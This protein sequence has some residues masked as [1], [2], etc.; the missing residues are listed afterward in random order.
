MSSARGWGPEIENSQ[1]QD[2]K[3]LTLQGSNAVQV[4]QQPPAPVSGLD[5]VT[6]GRHLL[7]IC[8]K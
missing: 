8:I 5:D 3:M 7:S 6:E 4:Q 1:Q 2:R